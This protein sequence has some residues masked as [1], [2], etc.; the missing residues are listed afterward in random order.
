[1]NTALLHYLLQNVQE[2]TK[3]DRLSLSDKVTFSASHDLAGKAREQRKRDKSMQDNTD[4]PDFESGL[5]TK[6]FLPRLLIP[7]TQ[8]LD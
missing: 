6:K 7:S 8:Q 3:R 1:M 5:F 2:R 4:F